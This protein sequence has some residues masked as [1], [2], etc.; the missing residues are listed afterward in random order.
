M[1]PEYEPSPASPFHIEAANWRDL[2]TLRRLEQVCFP[3]DVWPLWDLIGV[4]TLPS[5]LRLKA[6]VDG[7]M[8]GFIAA[9]IRRSEN[10]AWIAT[11]GVLPEFRGQGIGS[12]LLAACEAQATTARMRLNVR[13]SNETAIR[14]YR[15][16]GYEKVGLWPGYYQDGENA[17]IMEKKL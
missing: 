3:K 15:R 1:D 9:D 17:L 16:E 2:N 6:M 11:I 8:V 4:L 5:V 7:E 12:S 13:T 10:I 14:L